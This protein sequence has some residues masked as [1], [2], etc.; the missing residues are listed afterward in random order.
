MTLSA[1]GERQRNTK[2]GGGRREA[3]PERKGRQ[4]EDR[5]CRGDQGWGWKRPREAP[6]GAR[7]EA[8]ARALRGQSEATEVPATLPTWGGRGRWAAVPGKAEAPVS[9]VSLLQVWHESADREALRLSRAPKVTLLRT[10]NLACSCIRGPF[11][12]TTT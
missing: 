5:E 6:A 9:Q 2:A 4:E 3:G 1:T 8:E 10:K 12:A 11:V 7:A